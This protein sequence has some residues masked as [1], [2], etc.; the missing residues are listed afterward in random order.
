MHDD[1]LFTAPQVAK[2]CS[3]DL[4][5]I[6]NWVNRGEIRF[7]RTPGRHLRFRRRD[8]IDFLTKFG[9]PIPE[10]FAPGRPRVVIV[11]N[12]E[13]M[14]KGLERTLGKE[15]DVSA[16]GDHVDALIAVGRD[17]PSVVLLSAA[18]GDETRRV[19]ERL[20]TTARGLQVAVYGWDESASPPPSA[21]GV[22]HIVERDTRQIRQAVQSM[23]GG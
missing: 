12:D 16:Y 15:F 6:H 10:G 14:L 19:A 20:S 9:Y 11:E 17:K 5:T 22:R 3:T 13:K 4:K 2:I 8:V 7:F 23:L 18:G 1:D 21:E